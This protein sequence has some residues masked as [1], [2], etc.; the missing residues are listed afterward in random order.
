MRLLNRLRPAPQSTDRRQTALCPHPP[1]RRR[2]TPH[3]LRQS[4][5]GAARD[6]PFHEPAPDRRKVLL[7]IAD[8]AE[9]PHEL[10]AF[11]ISPAAA[12]DEVN[13]FS[14]SEMTHTIP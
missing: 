14:L 11:T 6:P 12:T 8:T 5:S 3:R 13:N 10:Q 7:D 9:F 2:R 1:L 4:P